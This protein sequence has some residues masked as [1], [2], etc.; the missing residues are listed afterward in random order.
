[1]AKQ[2]ESATAS[3]AFVTI[4]VGAKTFMW[5][6]L[7]DGYPGIIGMSFPSSKLPPHSLIIHMSGGAPRAT[8]AAN[9]QKSSS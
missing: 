9:Q 3:A 6:R 7:K 8:Q 5:M 4:G 2:A 1:V